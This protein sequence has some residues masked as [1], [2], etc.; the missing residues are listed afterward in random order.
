MLVTVLPESTPPIATARGTLVAVKLPMP[1]F[2]PF[3]QAATVPSEQSARLY[4]FPAVMAVTVLPAS[5]EPAAALTATGT[6]LSVLLLLP[7][8]PQL[9]FPQAA[10]V[11]SEHSAGAV[12]VVGGDHD[13]GFSLKR[14]ES[15]V[16]STARQ[17]TP[18]PV[19]LLL[20]SS[21]SPL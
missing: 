6:W 7:S 1:R 11:P 14:A 19:V 12:V 13:D 16:A 9:F 4:S 3:P 17:R 2:C 5:A 18:L 20:P 8:W 15:A 21:P 10:T